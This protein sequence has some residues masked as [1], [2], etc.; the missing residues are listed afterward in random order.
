MSTAIVYNKSIE[1]MFFDMVFSIKKEL[2]NLGED[3]FLIDN[4]SLAA[5]SDEEINFKKCI[6]FDKDIIQGMRLELLGVRLFNN[7]GSIELC[8][9]KRKC[10]EL[11]KRDFRVPETIYYPL[12][13]KEND[14]FFSNFANKVSE[15]LSLPLIAKTAF[16]SGGEQVFLLK[17]IEEVIN[18]QKKYYKVPHLY[19]KFIEE[20]KGKDIRVYVV[21]E[22]VVASML[23]ENENDFRSNI[24]MGGHGSP[25][26]ISEEIKE[27]AI[28]LCKLLGLDFAGI[29][30]LFSNDGNHYVCEVNSNAIFTAI[31]KI[32]NIN[33]A[34]EIAQWV[35]EMKSGPGLE[36]IYFADL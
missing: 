31:S 33:I 36:D 29:D 9:D 17:S 4:I 16:G 15:K 34:K 12:V 22:K 10:N 8:D 21:G 30:F 3:C 24:I 11:I 6:F 26:K 1:D 20:S 35:K 28:N 5:L 13:F 25:F 27:T 23:R 2:E 19:S 14:T 7:I 18:F 32:C